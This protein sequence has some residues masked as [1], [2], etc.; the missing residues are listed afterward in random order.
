MRTKLSNNH[1]KL[2][3]LL[4]FILTLCTTFYTTILILLTGS[5]YL[6]QSKI[7]KQRELISATTFFNKLLSILKY[8]SMIFKIVF[9]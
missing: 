6:I 4:S 3:L 9:V 7:N 8:S 2:N 1:L 5:C